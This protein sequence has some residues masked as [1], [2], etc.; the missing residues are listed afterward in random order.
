MQIYKKGQGKHTRVIT[1]LAVTGLSVVA[2]VSLS[3]TLSAYA[4]TQAPLIRYGVPTLL[5]I[6][7]GVLSLWIVNRPKSADFLIATEGEMKK[8]SW[9]NKK[10]IIGST[11]VVITTTFIL[12]A[13]LFGVDIAFAYIFQRLGISG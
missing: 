3:Q 7:I 8:V 4:T 2:A 11:K 10:E 12:A 13:I 9:S 1:F 6:L 5:V